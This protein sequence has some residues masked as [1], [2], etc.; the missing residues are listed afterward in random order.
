MRVKRF[1]A[2]N[3]KR[4]FATRLTT[5]HATSTKGSLSSAIFVNISS[6]L[7]GNG[8][9]STQNATSASASKSSALCVSSDATSLHST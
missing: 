3:D 2:S 6:N 8:R 5:C 1:H 4:F 7:R 9:S